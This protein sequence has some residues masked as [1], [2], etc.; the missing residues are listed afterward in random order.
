[1]IFF[2]S[3]KDTFERD[4][5]KHLLLIGSWSEKKNVTKRVL[6]MSKVIKSK[7]NARTE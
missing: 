3:L 4:D 1:M 7:K 6:N 2:L 5:I